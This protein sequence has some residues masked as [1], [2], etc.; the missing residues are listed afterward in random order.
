VEKVVELKTA[1]QTFF[2]N[3]RPVGFWHT[4]F[5]ALKP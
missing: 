5:P 4:G 3:D 2:R 1:F